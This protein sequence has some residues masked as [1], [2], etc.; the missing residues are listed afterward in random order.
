M[1]Y[2]AIVGGIYM[3]QQLVLYGAICYMEQQLVL[4][5]AICY[6]EQQFVLY[7]AISSWFF[8]AHPALFLHA[9]PSSGATQYAE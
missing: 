3:E 8:L 4:Y 2:G 6:V 9:P 7:G 5:G 1:L